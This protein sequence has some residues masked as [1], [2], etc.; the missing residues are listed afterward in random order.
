M[1]RPLAY[2][3]SVA[4]PPAGSFTLTC[5]PWLRFTEK[6]AVALEVLCNTIALEPSTLRKATLV[7]ELSCEDVMRAAYFETE[8]IVFAR[9]FE[10]LQLTMNPA[11][12]VREAR[13]PETIAVALGHPNSIIECSQGFGD[14]T[15]VPTRQAKSKQS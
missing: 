3:M 10:V 9:M 14:P 4:M 7:I 12:T 6:R 2:Q 1:A 15:Q 5:L 13:K 8:V 11:N